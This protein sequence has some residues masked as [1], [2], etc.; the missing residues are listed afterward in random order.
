MEY[1]KKGKISV[2][3]MCE[4]LVHLKEDILLFEKMGIEYLH[5]DVMDGKF[6][7]NYGLGTDYIRGLRELTNIPLDLHLMIESPE[8]KLKWFH[9][10]PTDLVTLHYESTP[11]IQRAL[12]KAKQYGCKVNLAINP[13][14]PICFVEEL[15][16]DIDGVTMLT[17]N[18]GFAGQKIVKNS[19]EKMKKL[20][21]YLEKRGYQD[22]EVEVDG[23][24]S[25]ENAE[26]LHSLGAAIFVAGTSSVFKD[27]RELRHNIFKLR[28][29]IS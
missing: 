7:P 25:F 2:S 10:Q 24:I 11:H 26:K 22:M 23:N 18:P 5:I 8:E 6:V 27:D 28:E 14:T 19:F 21:Q 20:K 17:V 1:K 9:I 3:M 15:L 4:D 29:S 12:E 13:G 16:D